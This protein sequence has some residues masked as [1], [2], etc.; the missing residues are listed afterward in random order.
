[1]MAFFSFCF[2]II[3]LHSLVVVLFIYLSVYYD[4]IQQKNDLDSENFTKITMTT[5]NNNNRQKTV[6]MTYFVLL[7]FT[8]IIYFRLSFTRYLK[9]LKK[10]SHH[11]QHHKEKLFDD[12]N[13][14]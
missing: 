5:N 13:I 14:A 4:K 12:S 11:S 10:N 9:L 1:M 7:C 8:H 2:Y 3:N 6:I